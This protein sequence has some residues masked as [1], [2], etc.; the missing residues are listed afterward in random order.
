MTYQRKKISVIGLGWLGKALAKQFI[1]DGDTVSGT[2]S[3]QEKCDK[4]IDEGLNCFVYQLGETLNQNLVDCDVLI[5][6]IP[7]R[8]EDYLQLLENFVRQLSDKQQ[9]IFV[10]STSVYPDLNRVV[11]ED[12][13]VDQ[14]S[15]HTGIS[16]LKAEEIF[17]KQGIS[18]TILRFS[19]LFGPGRNPGKFLAGKENIKGANTPV[20]LIHLD[21]CIGLIKAIVKNEIVGAAINGCADNH[22]TK[23]EFYTLAAKKAGLKPPQ[24]SDEES[25]YKIVDNTKS[26]ELLNYR[27]KHSDVLLAL[28]SI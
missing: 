16:I 25:D 17:P 27:Y 7:P 15:P 11:N 10:S 9:V 22:P 5:Y 3:S 23:K 2:V 19:G 28:D 1:I 21:D 4:M 6:T 20:N 24:F 12:D 14:P 13:A 8:G 26:K 18:A